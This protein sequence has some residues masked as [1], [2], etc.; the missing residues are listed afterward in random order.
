MRENE[1]ITKLR[2]IAFGEW[3]RTNCFIVGV[4][5]RTSYN[6][7]DDEGCSEITTDEL[8]QLFK[9]QEKTK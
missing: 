7:Q 1:E 3:I 5:E 6:L 4:A 9:K 2:S 8:Y